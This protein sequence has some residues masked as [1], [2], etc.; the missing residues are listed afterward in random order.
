VSQLMA[1]IASSSITKSGQAIAGNAAQVVVVRTNPGYGPAP[2]H[3]GRG[4]VVGVVCP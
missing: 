1:V 2:G 3:A 4:I